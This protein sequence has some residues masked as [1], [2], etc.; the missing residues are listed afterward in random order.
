MVNS[1][2]YGST[3]NFSQSGNTMVKMIT[4]IIGRVPIPGINK[5]VKIAGDGYNDGVLRQKQQ[6]RIRK[7]LDIEGL[8]SYE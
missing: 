2:P 8:L 6:E 7:A 3:A 4:D 1:L 5:L